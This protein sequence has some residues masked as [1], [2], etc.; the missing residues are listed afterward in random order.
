MVGV[1]ALTAVVSGQVQGVGFRYS[2]R[3]L[4]RQL[5]VTG[6]VRNRADGTVEVWAQ[7]PAGSLARFSAF[8]AT[9]PPG[10][11]V[12]GVDLHDADP[13]PSRSS[14]EISL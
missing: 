2:T 12:T 5:G 11:R 6:W 8:L 1:R 9:G 13:D 4:A 7:G 10:A 14:F 3:R